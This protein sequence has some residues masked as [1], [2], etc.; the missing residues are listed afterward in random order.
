MAQVFKKVRGTTSS[1]WIIGP[2]DIDTPSDEAVGVRTSAT[3]ELEVKESGGAWEPFTGGGLT[4]S[5]HEE[6]DTLVHEIAEDAYTEYTYAGNQID[7]IDIYT[8][9]TKT[10]KIRDFTYTYSGNRVQT[11][12]VRQYNAAGSVVKTMLYTYVYSSGR[13]ASVIA[14][15]S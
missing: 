15:E 13:V 3:G 12:T 1:E 7:T 2:G 14:V 6:L 8:D 11:E 10:L 5:Q 4:P 9:V